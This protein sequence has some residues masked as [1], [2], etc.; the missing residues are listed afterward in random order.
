MQ[1]A[2]HSQA[3][4]DV[5]SGGLRACAFQR[6]GGARFVTFGAG[7]HRLGHR[8]LDLL[9]DDRLALDV[10]RALDERAPE[11]HVAGAEGGQ[12]QRLEVRR[13][14]ATPAGVGGQRGHAAHVV[15]DF[16]GATHVGVHD[17]AV[18]PQDAGQ[19]RVLRVVETRQ[20]GLDMLECGVLVAQLHQLV[21][22]VAVQHRV[23]A[24]AARWRRVAQRLIHVG[25]RLLGFVARG[26]AAGDGV[27]Q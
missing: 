3:Q 14:R 20:S 24:V 25:K 11:G 22:E 17:D 10:A 27:E 6:R 9:F 1:V 2:A 4:P 13:Q 8:Q 23:V 18:D 19:A 26:V 12:R 15:Q 5:A 16:G 7:Q 21:R